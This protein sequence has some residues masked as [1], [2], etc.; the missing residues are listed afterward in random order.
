L[1]STA[2][3]KLVEK[4]NKIVRYWLYFC[5]FIFMVSILSSAEIGVALVL[6]FLLFGGGVLAIHKISKYKNFFD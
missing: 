3:Q 6:C 5:I 1:K 2:H 4:E